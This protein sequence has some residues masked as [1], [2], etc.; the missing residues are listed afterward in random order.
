[1]KLLVPQLKSGRVINVASANVHLVE[2]DYRS[3][4]GKGKAQVTVH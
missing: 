2:K 1:M 4:S 3:I